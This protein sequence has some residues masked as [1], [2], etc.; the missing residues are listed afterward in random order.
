[1]RLS[2]YGFVLLCLGGCQ[3]TQTATP[4]PEGI[5]LPQLAEEDRG[6]PLCGTGY[7][8]DGTRCIHQEPTGGAATTAYPAQMKVVDVTGGTGKEAGMGDLVS[9]D[10]T[11]SLTDGTV[12]DSSRPRGKPLQFRLGAGQVI[13]G[14]E[15]GVVGMK[16]G[17]VRKLTI[18]S[19]LA[20]GARG[21]PPTI[22]PNATLV[23]D[24]ELQAI[25]SE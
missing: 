4:R 15:R 12:V 1:M 6:D 7:K 24:V 21:V 13:K 14:F 19:D 20:Y 25:G 10:Y 16:P 11:A 8:W 22:P 17:G 2:T 3:P 23:F 18:P 9:V 5:P